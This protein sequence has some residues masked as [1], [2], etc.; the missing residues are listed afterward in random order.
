[1]KLLRWG[2]VAIRPT[3]ATSCSGSAC[4]VAAVVIVADAEAVL[5]GARGGAC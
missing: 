4:E 3:A 5:G 1:M 2:E